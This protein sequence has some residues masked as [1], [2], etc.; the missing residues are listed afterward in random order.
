MAEF[1]A[2]ATKIVIHCNTNKSLGKLGIETVKEV[3]DM[4]A[5]TQSATKEPKQVHALANR[6]DPECSPC[7]P[8][9]PAC[10]D[11]QP[12]GSAAPSLDPDVLTIATTICLNCDISHGGQQ[13]LPGELANYM[14]S[15]ARI[16]Q[17]ADRADCRR[18]REAFFKPY[19]TTDGSDGE[20]AVCKHFC[21]GVER[22]AERE[23]HH[24]EC[25]VLAALAP[26]KKEVK[27]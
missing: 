15:L 12:S 16:C 24:A 8:D 10:E 25:A 7:A 13:V 26:E 11:A 2:L 23:S 9:C 4:I 14:T 3:A 21:R 27:P 22:I 20:C 17:S 6:A 18:L 5:K 1:D 19:Y